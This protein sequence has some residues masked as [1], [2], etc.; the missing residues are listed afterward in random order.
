MEKVP[1]PTCSG[2]SKYQ[3]KLR[4]VLPLCL[5]GRLRVYLDMDFVT[6]AHN[7]QLKDEMLNWTY[8]LLYMQTTLEI[9]LV[10]NTAISLQVVITIIS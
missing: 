1:H 6:I 8:M 3:K 4:H 5:G 9:Q 2:N 10:Q 7:Y